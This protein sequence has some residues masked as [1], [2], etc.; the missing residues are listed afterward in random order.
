MLLV[1]T[2]G[3][4]KVANL[5]AQGLFE[6]PKNC[7]FVSGGHG[8][9]LAVPSWDSLATVSERIFADSSDPVLFCSLTLR[10]CLQQAL[11]FLSRSAQHLQIRPGIE[12]SLRELRTLSQASR[13]LL[14][15]LCSIRNRASISELVAITGIQRTLLEEIKALVETEETLKNN[16]GMEVD[17]DLLLR[18]RHEGFS[19]ALIARLLDVTRE[20]IHQSFQRIGAMPNQA[21]ISVSEPR[22][23][24]CGYSAAQ[25]SE[26]HALTYGLEETILE[27]Q[28]LGTNAVVIH[29]RLSLLAPFRLM[30]TQML[31]WFPSSESQNWIWETGMFSIQVPEEAGQFQPVP[32]LKILR[33]FKELQIDHADWQIVR[34]REELHSFCQSFGFPCWIVEGNSCSRAVN[35][36]EVDLI[37][38]MLSENPDVVILRQNAQAIE[39]HVDGVFGNQKLVAGVVSQHMGPVDT[40]EGDTVIVHPAPDLNQDDKR[41]LLKLAN[42]IC[43][44]LGVLGLFGMHVIRTDKGFA[45]RNFWIGATPYV[46]FHSRV[47]GASLPALSTRV[48]QGLSVNFQIHSASRYVFVKAPIFVGGMMGRSPSGHVLGVAL[49]FDEALRLALMAANIPQNPESFALMLGNLDYMDEVWE[50]LDALYFLKLTCFVSRPVYELIENHQDYGA[51]FVLISDAE[52]LD[53]MESARLEVLVLP[54]TSWNSY[55]VSRHNRT[56]QVAQ[57]NAVSCFNHVGLARRYV[58]SLL[59]GNLTLEKLA[60]PSQPLVDFKSYQSLNL[61]NPV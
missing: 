49:E 53:L 18:A 50:I 2:I 32:G 46:L 20:E 45:L 21:L 4:K 14:G 48:R 59:R 38:D 11:E 34:D 56:L 9:T 60:P 29:N 24:V 5:V 23:L 6:S 25:K 57:R 52:L 41:E 13:R 10:S 47:A 16:R 35:L 27:L 8:F 30:A 3:Q 19:E 55:A 15:I 54:P 51:Y 33:A 1:M 36:A 28:R 61:N 58:H 44:H 39:F 17:E 37:W 26:V 31:P 43:T 22:A 42:R 40:M 12:F 7:N